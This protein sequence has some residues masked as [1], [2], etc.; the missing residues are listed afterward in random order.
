MDRFTEFKSRQMNSHMRM[1]DY[2][3]RMYEVFRPMRMGMAGG[4]LNA[5][6]IIEIL[7]AG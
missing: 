3:A 7:K 2:Y 1:R 6:Q 5:T 4:E